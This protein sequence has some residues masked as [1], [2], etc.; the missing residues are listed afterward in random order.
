MDLNEVM[1]R[2]QRIIKERTCESC[3]DRNVC[4]ENIKKECIVPAS[5]FHRFYRGIPKND[6]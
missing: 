5:G 3:L 6:N 2:A 4:N 1:E